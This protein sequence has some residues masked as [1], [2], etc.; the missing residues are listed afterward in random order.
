[1]APIEKAKING[2][3]RYAA[4]NRKELAGYTRQ[5][6]AYRILRDEGET[7]PDW[8]VAR[9]FGNAVHQVI[10]N[11]I[12]GNP[13]GHLVREVEGT[14][15]YPVVNDFTE[16][17]PRYWAEFVR[18]H[19]VEIVS[20]EK[21]VVSD[22]WGYAGSYDILAYVDGV[23]TFVD[24]K[25]NAKGPHLWSVAMQNEAYRRADYILDFV[26][27]EQEELPQAERSMVLWLRPEG[28]NTWPLPN[29]PEVWKDFYAHLYLFQ[30]GKKGGGS[31][32]LEPIWPEGLIPP[33]RW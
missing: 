8:N 21:S 4:K 1:M 18:A 12:N 17:V 2:V 25:S 28:W 23:L 29:G 13:L 11:I 31:E 7:L 30:Q 5:E 15:T 32:D 9:A 16:W 10:E 14:A 26:T 27:G 19:K 6:D 33:R 24:A 3:A 20:C 22:R